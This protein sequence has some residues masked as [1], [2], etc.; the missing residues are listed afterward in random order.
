M[1]TTSP[2]PQPSSEGSSCVV[3]SPQTEIAQLCTSMP[4]SRANQLVFED[5]TH[6]PQDSAKVAPARPIAIK[7]HSTAPISGQVHE[8]SHRTSPA[9]T[10]ISI[11]IQQPM[12]RN[13]LPL[14]VSTS[15]T[16]QAIKQHVQRYCR[17]ELSDFDLIYNGQRLTQGP[18][19]Q[20]ALSPSAVIH[21][22]PRLVSGHSIT[23]SVRK[24]IK[25]K[26]TDE[27]SM[28][29]RPYQTRSGC[30]R[31]LQDIVPK[32]ILAMRPGDAERLKQA[33]YRLVFLPT[34]RGLQPAPVT[35]TMAVQLR[36][37]VKQLFR[38]PQ[39]QKS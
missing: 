5:A 26:R 29:H 22:Q 19:A 21:L 33:P 2:L 14:V 7:G 1:R 39:K 10:K 27:R 32:R 9:P 34:R 35:P 8:P 6:L 38:V 24:P 25:S 31:S 28:T 11:M 17:R 16:V 37:R 15:D 18:V 4:S 12:S 36:Q 13:R 3:T 23:T 20:W 30:K